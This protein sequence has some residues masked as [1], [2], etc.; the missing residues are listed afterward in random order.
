MVEQRRQALKKDNLDEYWNTVILMMK[1]EE[2]HFAKTL[3]RLALKLGMSEEV[4]GKS[5]ETFTK[6]PQKSKML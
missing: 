2:I 1:Q 5:Y 4:Y 6:S 3:E